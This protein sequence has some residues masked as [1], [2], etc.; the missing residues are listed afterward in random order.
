MNE[1]FFNQIKRLISQK[2]DPKEIMQITELGKAAVYNP[3]SKIWD[4]PN[5]E[6][7]ELYCQ[8]G[9]HKKKNVELVR[10]VKEIVN[11]DQSLTQK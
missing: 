10:K 8:P 5:M 11:E 4:Y 9:R 3:I 7:S 6:Y 1:S 2:V